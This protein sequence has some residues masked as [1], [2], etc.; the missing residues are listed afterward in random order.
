MIEL[1]MKKG[2]SKLSA[3]V[4]QSEKKKKNPSRNIKTFL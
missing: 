1:K 3:I 2:Q 4:C